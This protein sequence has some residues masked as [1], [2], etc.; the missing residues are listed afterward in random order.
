MPIP[1]LKTK[2]QDSWKNQVVTSSFT[3]NKRKEQK[4]QKVPG[5]R[6]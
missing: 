1:P 4:D 2:F 6:K 3:K 5:K